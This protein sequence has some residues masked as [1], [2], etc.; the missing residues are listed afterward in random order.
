MCV[1]GNCGAVIKVDGNKLFAETAGCFIVEIE[2]ENAAK[3]LFK[4]IPFKILGKTIK[5]EKLI[6]D[7]LFTAD[8]KKLQEAWQK[9]MKE[10]FS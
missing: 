9:P 8:V 2:N 1:G 10:I 3:E 6:V 7:G 5:Q 4:G